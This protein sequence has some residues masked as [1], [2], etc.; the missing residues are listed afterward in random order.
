MKD[1]KAI[2]QG[3]GL[4][5]T[6]AELDRIVQA[7][8]GLEE[9]LRPLLRELSPELEPDTVFHAGENGA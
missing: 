5:A 2:A 9:T 7:L 1:W 3:A 6:G 4:E 8:S